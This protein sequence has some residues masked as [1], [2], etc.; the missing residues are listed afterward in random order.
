[1]KSKLI[2]FVLAVLM[3]GAASA[4]AQDSAADATDMQA[5]RT[6]VQADKRAYVASMLKLTDAEAKKFWP[7]YDAYQRDVDTANRMR[8]LAL[9]GLVGRDKPMTDLYARNLARDLI[10]ADELE[11][12]ARRTLHNRLMR[13]LPATKAARCLQLESKIRAAQG[14]DIAATFPLIR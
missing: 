13:A 5:L 11:I 12:K 6:A 1:M 7:L 4:R 10:A 9:E 8:A 2:A 14:Y 3:L